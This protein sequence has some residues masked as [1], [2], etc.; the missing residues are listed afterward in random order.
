MAERQRV[1]DEAD[2][3]RRRRLRCWLV[4]LAVMGALYGLGT[5]YWHVVTGESWGDSLAFALTLTI[6]AVVG[7]W[8]AAV[9]RR[10]AGRDDG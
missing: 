6:S 3:R 8:I 7:Q 4:A 1:G 5:V 2:P 10:R 9:I